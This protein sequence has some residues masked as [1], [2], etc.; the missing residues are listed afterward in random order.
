MYTTGNNAGDQAVAAKNAPMSSLRKT[1][2]F[3][4]L[5]YILTFI[6]IPTLSLYQSIHD[7]NY[8]LGSGPDTP[9]IIGGL[10]EIIVA[11]SGITTAII[12][13]PVLKRQSERLALGLVAARVLEASTMFVGF[14]FLLTAVTLRQ[15]GVGAD[16]MVTSHALVTLYDRI[17]LLGQAF[18]PAIDDML[19]GILLYKSRLVPRTLSLIGI[20]GAFPLIAG[21]L[22]VLFGHIEFRSVLSGLSAVMVAVFEFSLGIYLVVRGF[23]P[24]AITAGM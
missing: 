21:Y 4:G 11:L 15:E 23:K 14:A 6:S 1:A 13:Y 12:L 9:V 5:V 20:I 22:A 18:I 19:L 3:A 8:V 7:Q 10:L 17:F 16:A 24:S 2:L